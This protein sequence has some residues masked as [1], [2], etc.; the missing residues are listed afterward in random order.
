MLKLF[1]SGFFRGSAKEER[2]LQEHRDAA[3][4]LDS[5]K[6]EALALA[7]I[8]KERRQLLVA[9]GDTGFLPSATEEERRN[10]ADV[11]A[12]VS[13]REKRLS[14]AF[15]GI[16]EGAKQLAVEWKEKEVKRGSLRLAPEVGGPGMEMGPM[17]KENNSYAANKR[18]GRGSVP[19]DVTKR[20]LPRRE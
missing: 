16:S 12:C 9:L 19:G 13:R 18:K 7:R 3:K 15:S 17:N 5:S 14:E 11:T 2:T 8:E 20:H 1:G 6:V 4:I 10:L